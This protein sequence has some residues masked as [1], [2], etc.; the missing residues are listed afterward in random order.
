MSFAW[1]KSGT[2]ASE[3][4]KH[5]LGLDTRSWSLHLLMRLLSSVQL[6][7]L[8]SQSRLSLPSADNGP[9]RPGHPHFLPSTSKCGSRQVAG[10]YLSAHPLPRPQSTFGK[11]RARSLNNRL[12]VL[13]LEDVPSG[14]LW[15][16]GERV[17]RQVCPPPSFASS[18]LRFPPE[19]DPISACALSRQ[20]GLEDKGVSLAQDLALVA[21][22][23]RRASVALSLSPHNQSLPS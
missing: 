1:E 7:P 6:R 15:T 10:A 16:A 22:L 13:I 20:R 14:A 23:R 9:I 4:A 12:A 8:P 2:V 5:N 17:E 11:R 21:R 18:D 19:T 3:S